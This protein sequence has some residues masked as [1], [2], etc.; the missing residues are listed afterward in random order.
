MMLKSPEIG[1]LYFIWIML[2]ITTVETSLKEMLPLLYLLIVNSQ[3]LISKIT[4]RLL[5]QQSLI[6][7]K[8]CMPWSR[9][10]QLGIHMRAQKIS[11]TASM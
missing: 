3:A 10:S 11:K 8:I 6:H 5:S 1:T 7:P 9:D 4:Y 2:T